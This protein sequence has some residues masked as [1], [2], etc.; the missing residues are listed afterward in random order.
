MTVYRHASAVKAIAEKLIA[1]HHNHLDGT[2]IE[3]VFRDKAANSGGKE[4]W[5][6]A[7]KISGLNAYLAGDIG[8][9]VDV[10]DF[11]VI[12]IAEDVWRILDGDQRVAL[13]DHELHHCTIAINDDNVVTGLAIAPHDLEE[14][15]A[16]VERHGLWRPDITEFLKAAHDSGQLSI[17][18]K[19]MTI[20]ANGEESG[21]F[22]QHDLDTIAAG[23]H[24]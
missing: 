9:G 15:K 6:K 23:I 5:G 2:H 13:V 18:D 20:S 21:P 16:V 3:Y 19:T 7:R 4:V 11:F 22:S 1:D 8:E 12:E 10:E 24:A 14:F 17:F